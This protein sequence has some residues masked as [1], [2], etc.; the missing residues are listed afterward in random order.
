MEARCVFID[1]PVAVYLH[2]APDMLEAFDRLR[3]L[4]EVASKR[5]SEEQKQDMRLHSFYFEVS[6]FGQG[7][8]TKKILP[9]SEDDFKQ[10][11]AQTDSAKWNGY[12]V[13]RTSDN[14]GRVWQPA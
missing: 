1:G 9:V 4:V 12:H 14:G 10:F 7:D 3:K 13:W 6:V 8:I 2:D 11:I 5:F